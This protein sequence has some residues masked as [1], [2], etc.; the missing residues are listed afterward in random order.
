MVLAVNRP[1]A[2]PDVNESDADFTVV[3]DDLRF[4]M[5]AVKTVG[6]GFV[7]TL[8]AERERGGRFTAFDEFCRRMYGQDLN[9]RAIES[10]IRA[11][12][13]DSLGCKRKA[14][15]Q[16]L[17]TVLDSVTSAGRKNVAGQMDLFGMDAD[18]GGAAAETMVLPDVEEFSP[19]ELMRMEREMTGLYL[20]GH[21]MDGYRDTAR[22]LGAV[23]IGEVMADFAAED[24]PR[25]FRDNQFVTLA[26][27]IESFKTRTTKN[28]SLMCYVQLEDDSGAMELIVFQ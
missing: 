9:R 21:P 27:V 14:L 8:M 23:P 4:G 15:L 1:A 16:V 26:G 2:A 18:N 28:N 10:L 11:G 22:R 7:K 13:F 19:D 25:Q 12:A 6:R 20:S 17:D 5:A 3:G 24:G